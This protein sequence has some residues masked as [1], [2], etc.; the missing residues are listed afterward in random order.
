MLIVISIRC[1]AH[2]V[3]PRYLRCNMYLQI[4]AAESLPH[5]FSHNQPLVSRL[6]LW[7]MM[8]MCADSDSKLKEVVE[9]CGHTLACRLCTLTLR[10]SLVKFFLMLLS[11]LMLSLS[12]RA[13][14]C[15]HKHFHRTHHPPP[16]PLEPSHLS[17][18]IG[19]D[20]NSISARIMALLRTKGTVLFISSACSNLPSQRRCR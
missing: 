8:L 11:K 5:Y 6:W 17:T 18:W 3:M 19:L 20:A 4:W 1:N 15:L 14:A 2:N 7:R 9:V 10:V 13:H 12:L 16:L